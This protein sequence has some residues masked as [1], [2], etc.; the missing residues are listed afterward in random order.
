MTRF[1]G[2]RFRQIIGDLIDERILRNYRRIRVSLGRR[3]PHF[4]LKTIKPLDRLAECLLSARHSRER[5]NPASLHP[6]G[7]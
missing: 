3:F 2:H 7:P 1:P 5:G 6:T 4:F